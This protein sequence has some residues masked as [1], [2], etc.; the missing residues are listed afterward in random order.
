MPVSRQY[1]SALRKRA[2]VVQTTVAVSAQSQWD[3]MNAGRLPRD[4]LKRD[5]KEKKALLALAVEPLVPI[6]ITVLD[7]N[8]DD[9][10]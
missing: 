6:A 1:R 4:F 10:S 5:Y 2:G 3:L 8:E 9:A 7:R